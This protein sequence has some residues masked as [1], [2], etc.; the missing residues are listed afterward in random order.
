M[1]LMQRLRNDESGAA[2]ITA[3]LCTMVMLALGLALLS[4]VDTQANESTDEVTRDRAFNLAESVL[5]SEAFVLGRNW[6]DL[7]PSPNPACNAA[8]AGFG[9]TIGSTTAPS[10]PTARLRPTSTSATP[11]PPTRARPGRSTSATT[12]ARPSGTTAA[13]QRHLGC[14]RQRA[15]V[16]PRTGHG[17]QQDP[18]VVGLVKVR[19]TGALNPKYGLVSGQLTE[20]LGPA[21]AR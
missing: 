19:E 11:T 21:T 14:E 1:Q 3:L 16:G 9:D 10:V 7:V 8:V 18:Y 13:R 4:I 17:R 2:L 12:T 20:D 15:A 6:P 5:T